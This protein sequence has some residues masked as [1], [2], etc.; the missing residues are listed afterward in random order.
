MAEGKNCNISR[1]DA[2]SA[3]R[4]LCMRPEDWW[5]LIMKAKS[6]FDGKFYFFID[7]GA[8][9][10]REYFLL[11]LPACVKWHRA[12]SYIQNEEKECKLSG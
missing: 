7:K 9:V 6:P 2:K 4:N 1:S 3:F 10:W 8:P 11:S 12:P 5:L